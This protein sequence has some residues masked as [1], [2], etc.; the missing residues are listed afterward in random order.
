MMKRHLIYHTQISVNDDQAKS[1]PVSIQLNDQSEVHSSLESISKDG[2]TLNCD[3]QTLHR[4][5]PNNISVSPKQP[6]LLPVSFTL[7]ENIDTMC[8]VVY[9]RRL[10]KDTFQLEMRFQEISERESDLVD[11]YVEDTL[12]RKHA[13]RNQQSLLPMA[14]VA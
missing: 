3:Q 2:L 1:N 4:L 9:V 8:N 10:S 5:L 12:K 14:K 11:Q 7:Y 13:E 6:V